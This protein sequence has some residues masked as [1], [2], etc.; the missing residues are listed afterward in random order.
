MPVSHRHSLPDTVQLPR[1]ARR[2]S[3]ASIAHLDVSKPVLPTCWLVGR[4]RTSL[5]GSEARPRAARARRHG[6]PGWFRYSHG[7]VVDADRRNPGGDRV[8]CAYVRDRPREVASELRRR[9]DCHKG[10]AGLAVMPKA[11]P[12]AQPPSTPVS[13]HLQTTCSLVLLGRHHGTNSRTQSLQSALTAQVTQRP[14][15]ELTIFTLLPCFTC[16]L[17]YRCTHMLSERSCKSVQD[18]VRASV[19]AFGQCRAMS[20][21]FA[22]SSV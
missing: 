17:S 6:P 9:Q 5:H 12:Q 8:S 4:L 22:S 1:T 10:R 15:G 19:Q 14:G 18:F 3:A 11:L 20:L 7:S 16:T 2:T 21:V 13:P